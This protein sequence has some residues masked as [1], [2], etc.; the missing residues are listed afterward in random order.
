MNCDIL[1]FNRLKW[2]IYKLKLWL[3]SL[4]ADFNWAV[5]FRNLL[6]WELKESD[7]NDR[8]QEGQS[9]LSLKMLVL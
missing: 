1:F 4:I 3:P 2:I 5:L 6:Q 8:R 9:L 7:E